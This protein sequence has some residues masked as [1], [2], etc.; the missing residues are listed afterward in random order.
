[1]VRP[2]LL[3]NSL[4]VNLREIRICFILAPIFILGPINPIGIII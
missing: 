2:I 3:A 4:S 1:V